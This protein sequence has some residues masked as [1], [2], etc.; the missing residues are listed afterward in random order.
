[1]NG[2]TV[3]VSC[4]SG[5]AYAQRPA[6]FRWAGRQY[7]VEEV[8]RTWREPQGPHFHVRTIGDGRF[9][10]AYLEAIDQWRLKT[11]KKEDQR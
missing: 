11:I 8:E 6:S 7:T 3:H 9:H 1:V 10:L 2:E 5:H 4:Y